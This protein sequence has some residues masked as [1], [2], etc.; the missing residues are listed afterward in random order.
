MEEVGYTCFFI[1]GKLDNIDIKSLKKD[2]LKSFE[3]NK[4]VGA[5]ITDVRNEDNI[6]QKLI[7]VV[8]Q[9]Q[10]KFLKNILKK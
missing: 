6:N 5:D 4:K 2:C 7:N 9:I 3:N 1:H 8:T 10:E